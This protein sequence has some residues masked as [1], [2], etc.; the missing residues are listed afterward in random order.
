MFATCVFEYSPCVGPPPRLRFSPS[1]SSVDDIIIDVLIR[2]SETLSK[3]SVKDSVKYYCRIAT[4][5]MLLCFMLSLKSD[6]SHLLGICF[7]MI[8]SPIEIHLFPGVWG[9]RSNRTRC[10]FMTLFIL[11]CVSMHSMCNGKVSV[12][13]LKPIELE[14]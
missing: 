12:H 11:E 9:S 14:A 10:S 7:C 6:A 2:S 8:V 5:V 1:L 13:Q 4:R 3:K